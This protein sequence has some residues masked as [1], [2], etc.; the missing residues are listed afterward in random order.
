VPVV[1]LAAAVVVW[2]VGGPGAVPT[3]RR[4]ERS[5]P[6]PDADPV[7]RTYVAIRQGAYSEI[8]D[9]TYD[10]LDRA[11]TA[12]AGCH[13]REIP[14]R[15]RAAAK[16]GLADPAGLRRS[17]EG[18]DGMIQWAVALETGSPL[19]WDFWRTYESS[20]ARFQVRLTQWLGKV[21]QQLHALGFTP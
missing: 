3:R 14:W 17:R 7:S 8:L 9:A 13:L 19:R 10:R 15:R 12:R 2:A 21:D 1:L 18:L 4:G 5:A 16:L 20:R 11:V 6:P